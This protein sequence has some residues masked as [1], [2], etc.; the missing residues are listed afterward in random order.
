MR[1]LFVNGHGIDTEAGGAERY[2]ADLERALEAAALPL[3]VERDDERWLE[4]HVGIFR[5]VVPVR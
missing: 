4:E 1:I 3:A 2:V 5:G